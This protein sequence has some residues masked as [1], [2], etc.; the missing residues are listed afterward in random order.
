MLALAE[1]RGLVPAWVKRSFRDGKF[2]TAG[3]KIR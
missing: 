2:I 3:M 1:K